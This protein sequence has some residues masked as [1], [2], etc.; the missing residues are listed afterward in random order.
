MDGRE[1]GGG[2]CPAF[3]T[4]SVHEIG[5]R[6]GNGFLFRGLV[7][8]VEE[9]AILVFDAGPDRFDRMHVSDAALVLLWN[10][11]LCDH[12]DLGGG[13]VDESTPTSVVLHHVWRVLLC[14]QYLDES[15]NL[16][17]HYR[18][19]GPAGCP[20]ACSSRRNLLFPR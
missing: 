5:L 6:A 12:A 7:V 3:Q 15:G 9:A 8:A 19:A 2:P 11:S 18:G 14:W 4:A 13:H 16:L 17:S 10:F 1:P 20:P